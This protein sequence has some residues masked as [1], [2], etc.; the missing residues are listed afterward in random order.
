[1]V[2]P[3]AEVGRGDPFLSSDNVK[4]LTGVFLVL[5]AGE[6]AGQ[7]HERWGQNYGFTDGETEALGASAVH[8]SCYK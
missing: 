8:S 7:P 4:T 1:M 2:D 6:A 5:P 3:T